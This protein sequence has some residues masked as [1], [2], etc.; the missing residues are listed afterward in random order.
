MRENTERRAWI[1]VVTAFVIFCALVIAAPLA[2]RWYLLNSET[3]QDVSVSLVSGTVLLTRPGAALSEAV[4][5]T[6]GGLGEGAQVDS[7][8]GSQA[9]LSFYAP[10][11]T[12]ALGAMQLYGGSRLRLSLL[13]SPRFDWSPRPHRM[14]IDMQRG[15][16]RVSLAVNV[17]RAVMI[18]LRTPH[19]LVLLER[20]GSYSIEVTDQ[21]TDVA[22]RDGAATV[23]AAGQTV[24]LAA[25]ER[26][27]VPAGSPPQGVLTG[28]RN[29]IVNGD[30]TAPL[31][32]D[33]TTFKDRY[34]PN[35]VEG[36]IELT[37]NAGHSAVHF[38]RPGTNWGR[39]GI[40]HRINRDV[41]DY[42]TLR[43][44]LAVRIAQQNLSICG[45]LG[46][47]C[48]VMVKI[49]YTDI[50]GGNH[51]WVQGFYYL[52][53]PANTQPVRCIT[54]PPPS[55]PHLR[56]TQG[57]WFFYD[58]PE[59]I[60]LFKSAGFTPA[61]ISAISIYAE[62]HAFDSYVSEVELLAGD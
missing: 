4:V 40:R 3:S 27:I 1:I 16:A 49:E 38:N 14:M 54:C 34:D 61:V 59:L 12:T 13:R 52:P 60:S 50:A 53:D 47:E 7:D 8:P 15:R 41:R 43:L 20:A 57:S 29:L 33:W 32:P 26:T 6:V 36:R 21:S 11:K 22:V 10:D 24:I 17:A 51:E 45:S 18:T 23:I 39:I 62:G 2:I 19:G 37:V 30:F 44:H 5:E 46:S 58:S 42:H 56:V 28:D 25:N 55:G 35:D 9:V 31:S 48:P